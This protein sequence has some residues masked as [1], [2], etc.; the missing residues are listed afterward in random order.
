M[1]G[2][3]SLIQVSELIFFLQAK[4]LPSSLQACVLE[5]DR[6]GFTFWLWLFLI[7]LIYLS[8]PRLFICKMEL[9]KCFFQ[10]IFVRNN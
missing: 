9:L 2:D 6:P 7:Y 8:N 3:H 5:Q 4:N 1:P 10:K